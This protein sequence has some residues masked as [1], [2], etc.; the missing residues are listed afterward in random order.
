MKGR[1]ENFSLGQETGGDIR[2]GY[3][4]T[5][6]ERQMK[7]GNHLLQVLLLSKNPALNA[8]SFYSWSSL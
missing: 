5:S 2:S 4:M 1:T 6:Q 7:N 3:Q 8:S